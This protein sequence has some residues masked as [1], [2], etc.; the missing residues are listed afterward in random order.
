MNF[1]NNFIHKKLSYL[2][3]LFGVFFATAQT[4]QNLE[5][6]QIAGDGNPTANGPT[7]STPI[8]FV[9]NADNPTGNGY[10]TYSP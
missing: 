9:R 2:L 5:M 3:L 7:L 1:T 6:V 8:N 4:N 10:A